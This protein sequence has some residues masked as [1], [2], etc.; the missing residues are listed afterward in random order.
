MQPDHSDTSDS[1]E[2]Q[3]EESEDY[4]ILSVQSNEQNEQMV[5]N[6]ENVNISDNDQCEVT[7][8]MIIIAS[9]QNDDILKV[10]AAVPPYVIVGQKDQDICV[11]TENQYLQNKLKETFP[12]A[13]I[14][15]VDSD[16]KTNEEAHKMQSSLNWR[17]FK[18]LNSGS[19][20][21]ESVVLIKI[22]YTPIEETDI[23]EAKAFAKFIAQN[24]TQKYYNNKL[25]FQ[26][27]SNFLDSFA[28]MKQSNELV[29]QTGTVVEFSFKQF[30]CAVIAQVLI[31]VNDV[32]KYID[33]INQYDRINMSFCCYDKRIQKKTFKKEGNQNF[34]NIILSHVTQ[35]D[36]EKIENYLKQ[37]KGIKIQKQEENKKENPNK[38]KPSVE[39][40]EKKEMKVQQPI[41]KAKT[42]KKEQPPKQ[43]SKNCGKAQVAQQI[44]NKNVVQ[45]FVT[46]NLHDMPD[47]AKIL[48]AALKPRI[49]KNCTFK[50]LTK[51]DLSIK[52]NQESLEQVK[53]AITTYSPNLIFTQKPVKIETHKLNNTN[54][55]QV[56]ILKNQVSIVVKLE[57]YPEEAAQTL[58]PTI[59]SV[60][61][62]SGNAF[63]QGVNIIIQIDPTEVE[64][65]ESYLKCIQFNDQEIEFSKL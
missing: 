60:I 57:K 43:V 25:F 23:N 8:K 55:Q 45:F 4:S 63:I 40:K 18:Y 21:Q 7:A 64:L 46:I 34:V 30:Q 50:A 5:E 49:P 2:I 39:A 26:V 22:R 20:N 17:C 1:F 32:E 10:K 61:P 38:V 33:V 48:E 13:H 53:K 51:G 52:C 15:V 41:T 59:Q 3:C 44:D 42:L 36:V 31:H 35:T 58:L 9:L 54:I 19:L 28:Q 37:F 56:G 6:N 27:G 47:T 11:F 24:Y 65:V 12:Q 62:S 14:N 29:D 16:L